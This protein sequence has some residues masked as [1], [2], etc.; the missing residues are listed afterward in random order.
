MLDFHE[1]T[2]RFRHRLQHTAARLASDVIS[3]EDVGPELHVNELVEL[4]LANAT[5][6][7]GIIIGNIDILDIRFGN[8]W[9]NINHKL[10]KN[11][12]IE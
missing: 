11:A 1:H 9:T 6:N 8:L 10:F 2:L 12:G 4:P 5:N 3:I 7:E